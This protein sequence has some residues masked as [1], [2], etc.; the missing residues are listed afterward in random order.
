MVDLC[1]SSATRVQ[2]ISTEIAPTE[3]PWRL[4]N[5]L[6]KKKAIKT[7]PKKGHE[8]CLLCWPADVKKR[9]GVEQGKVSHVGLA[10]AY[11]VSPFRPIY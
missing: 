3:I 8:H 6:G 10:N 1:G 9:V 2:H 7:T 11:L 4:K 5:N